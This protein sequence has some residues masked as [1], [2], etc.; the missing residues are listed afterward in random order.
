M[1]ITSS[2]RPWSSQSPPPLFSLI[3][4]MNIVILHLVELGLETS[5]AS[6]TTN[7][8]HPSNRQVQQCVHHHR[9]LSGEYIHTGSLSV[10][11]IL[12][13]SIHTGIL[14]RKMLYQAFTAM[15][16]TVL[17]AQT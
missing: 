6:I 11:L 8:V 3:S 4:F 5:A 2:S 16:G 17:F 1:R 9:K 14:F 10:P 7:T 12:A 15:V 13:S